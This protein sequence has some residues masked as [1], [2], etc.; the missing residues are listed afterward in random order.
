MNAGDGQVAPA[1]STVATPPSVI[2][3]DQFGN[4]VSGVT[5]IFAVASGG[6]SVTGATAVTNASGIAT[7]G[8]WRLGPIPGLNTLTATSGTLTGSPITFTAVGL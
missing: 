2:V 3:T 6:G 7:V 5:V 1:G 4:P 8:S